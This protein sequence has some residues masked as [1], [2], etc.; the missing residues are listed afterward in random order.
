LPPPWIA[1]ACHRVSDDRD[2]KL[3]QSR[4]AASC[5]TPSPR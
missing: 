4:A 3:S 2:S 5:R 1:V